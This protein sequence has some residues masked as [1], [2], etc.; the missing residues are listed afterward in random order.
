MTDRYDADDLI[1]YAEALFAAG[2][3]DAD[4]AAV[5]APLMVEADLMGHT[6]HGLQLVPAYLG[7]LANGG[8]TAT[9]EPETLSD[10]GAVVTWDGRRL[11]GVWLTASAIDLAVDRARTYGTCT[12]AIRRSHHIACL[13]AFLERATRHGMMVTLASSDP[14]VASVAPF[15]G[16]RPAFTPDPIAVGIPTAADPILIDVS[17][18]ITTNGLTGRLHSEG[19]H[20]EHFWL[21]DNDGN[22]SRDPGVLFSDPPGSI[23]PI[24]GL[25]HGHKGYGL[26]LMVESLTQA[27]PGHGRADP[28]EGWGAGV[29]VQVQDPSAF[30]G[31]DAF[32]RQ[33]DHLAELCRSNPPRPG[34][35]S[36]RLPG[37]GALARKRAALRD[38][39]ELYPGIIDGLGKWATSLGVAPPAPR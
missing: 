30:A 35:A 34:V 32:T 25:D 29:W 31:S 21:L 17:A 20:L 13:A 27:L 19:R 12:V 6:T 15:G 36:V 22:P 8:M 10:R 28:P 39:V 38:G 26:A 11:S 16:R 5:V 4:Q 7:A 37:D 3:L 23:L 9:G 24:G 2:G 14:S 1:R 33:T 18:S